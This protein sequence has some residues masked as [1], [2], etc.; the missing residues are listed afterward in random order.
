M[1]VPPANFGIAEE[2]IYRCSKLETLNLSFIETLNVKT[3]LF[4]GG[5]EPSKFFKEFFNTTSIEWCLV[6]TTDFSSA[7]R[8][9]DNANKSST[10]SKEN[11]I[12]TDSDDFM[13]EL[14][15]SGM[16]SKKLHVHQNYH[17]TDED[18]L[19]LIKST[20][21]KKTF[22]LLLNTEKYN[23]LL[24]DRTSIIIGI[25]RKI[26]KWNISSIINEYR[27]FSGKNRSYFAETF[28][29]ILE[30]VIEQEK[31]DN[32]A[33]MD[34]MNRM[35]ASIDAVPSS[36]NVDMRRK[37]SNAVIV[38]EDDLCRSP[39]VPSRILRIIEEV[40]TRKYK[41]VPTDKLE[42]KKSTS[43]LGIFGNRYRLAFNKRENGNYKY[44][45]SDSEDPSDAV[46]LKIP[47]ESFLPKWLLFQRDLWE[48]E[49]VPE[50]HN[51]YKEHIFI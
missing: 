27:L 18:E 44:Y 3:V 35:D 40:E 47:C 29:E 9:V 50:E 38:T 34:H 8:P 43:S 22:K 5:Q 16:S 14:R 15:P 6:K 23:I 45:K 7:G 41:D 21:L 48:R 17:L 2:G 37:L 46:K 36:L 49:N 13:G 25:L 4:V 28:L 51:F 11:T 20:C 12:N 1:L 30:V 26:Q 42:L 39:E 31:D 19:M 24:V 10:D 32:F 33:I